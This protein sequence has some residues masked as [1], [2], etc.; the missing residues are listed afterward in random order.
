MSANLKPWLSQIVKLTPEQ[1]TVVKALE[2]GNGIFKCPFCKAAHTFRV[3][4]GEELLVYYMMY[5]CGFAV[6]IRTDFYPHQKKAS[7]PDEKP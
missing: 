1:E 6:E 7:L 5:P 4:P 3:H 2:P